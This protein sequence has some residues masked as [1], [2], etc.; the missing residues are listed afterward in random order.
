MSDSLNTLSSPL[1]NGSMT[2]FAGDNDFL[3]DTS[4][5]DPIGLTLF[6]EKF[7]FNNIAG[8]NFGDTDALPN[9]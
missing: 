3:F 4:F 2:I 5:G 7:F 8:D 9:E 1:L 6:T